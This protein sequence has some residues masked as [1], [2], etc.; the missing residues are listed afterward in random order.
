MTL[1]HYSTA[2]NCTKIMIKS[3]NVY[4]V[5]ANLKNLSWCDVIQQIKNHRHNGN[6][7][8]YWFM[9]NKKLGEMNKN[10]SIHIK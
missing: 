3:V 1:E 5:T 6:Q 9:Y 2:V 7:N 10:M 8:F 4:F